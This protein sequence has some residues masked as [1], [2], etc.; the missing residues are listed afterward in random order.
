MSEAGG[1][2]GLGIDLGRLERHSQENRRLALTPGRI[3]HAR[4][5]ARRAGLHAAA[6]GHHDGQRNRRVR[7][8][9][10]RILRALAIRLCS[11]RTLSGERAADFSAQVLKV[12]RGDP[13]LRVELQNSGGFL[14]GMRRR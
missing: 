6:V 13:Q 10:W 4:T 3:V 7:G 11:R 1:K 9:W 14:V 8:R 12:T 2:L 5:V